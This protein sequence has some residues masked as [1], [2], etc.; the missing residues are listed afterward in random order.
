MLLSI[1]VSLLVFLNIAAPAAGGQ[2]Q[3][4]G[5][6]NWARA[7]NPLYGQR[8]RP[9]D[10][11]DAIQK[12]PFSAPQLSAEWSRL[13]TFSYLRHDDRAELPQLFISG[14]CTISLDSVDGTARLTK[15]WQDLSVDIWHLMHACVSPSGLG[16][17]S[18]KGGFQFRIIGTVSLDAELRADWEYCFQRATSDLKTSLAECLEPLI[19]QR[20]GATRGGLRGTDAG[21]PATS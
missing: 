17:V 11:K 7:C 1:I 19:Q 13:R 5:L 12:L 4:P 10:C 18:N 15:S 16:G 21:P 20:L 8:I 2:V 9:Q 3:P 14:S 6:Y